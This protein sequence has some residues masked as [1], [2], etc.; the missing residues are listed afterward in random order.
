M[1]VGEGQFLKIINHGTKELL[2]TLKVLDEQTIHGI[3]CH[4]D[5]QGYDTTSSWATLLVWGGSYVS[6]IEVIIS[7]DLSSTEKVHMN[8][9]L[10]PID[11]GDWIL[12]ACFIIPDTD[13]SPGGS[14]GVGA[15]LV[16]AHNNVLILQA[17]MLANLG[18]SMKPTIKAVISGPPSM[19]YSAH[20]FPTETGCV[21]S[22]STGCVLVAAGTFFGETILWSFIPGSYDVSRSVLHRIFRGHQGSVFGVQISEKSENGASQRLL[23][24]CSDDRTIRIWDVSNLSTYL[25]ADEVNPYLQTSLNVETSEASSVYSVA[26]GMGHASRIWGLRFLGQRDGYWGLISYGED[27]TAQTWLLYPKPSD[28]AISPKSSES[29]IE[30]QHLKTYRYH[31]G[32]N[33]NAITIF[34]DSIDS[35]L[36]ADGGA[37]GQITSYYVTINELGLK[38]RD[39]SYHHRVEDVYTALPTESKM[40]KGFENSNSKQPRPQIGDI[41][42]SLSGYWQLS[43]K[44]IG[45]SGSEN[46]GNLEGTATFTSRHPTDDS[47][48][49]EELYSEVGCFI[50]PKGLRFETYRQ[51]VWRFDTLTQNIDVWFV[52]ADDQ[53]SVDYL[54]HA[55]KF[56]DKDSEG[57]RDTDM[58]ELTA[59][60]DHLCGK[61]N[62]QVKYTFQVENQSVTRW[63]TR[64][65]VCG[66]SK[67]YV[68]ESTYTRKVEPEP[69]YDNE[70]ILTQLPTPEPKS[71]GQRIT[72]QSQSLKNHSQKPEHDAFKTFCWLNK[73]EFLVSTE[74]GI[75]LLGTL[76]HDQHNVP[77]I[78]YHFVARQKHLESSCIATSIRSPAVAWLTGTEGS[79]YFY[80]HSTRTLKFMFKLPK[81]VAFL[82]A[83]VLPVEWGLDSKVD[84]PDS[85]D[86]PGAP[87]QVGSWKRK[88]IGIVATSLWSFS[89]SIIFFEIVGAGPPTDVKF[90]EIK[91]PADFVVT[92]SHFIEKEGGF[93]VLGSRKG[94]L[95]VWD[96]TAYLDAQIKPLVLRVLVHD[97]SVTSIV[98][99]QDESAGSKN[100]MIN[101]VTTG[102]DGRYKVH[103][104]TLVSRRYNGDDVPR[105]ET[106]HDCKLSFGPFIEGAYLSPLYKELIFWGF[107]SK[108]FVVW[109][110]SQ[111]AEVI[112]VECGNAHRNWDFAPHDSGNCGG[113]FVWTQAKLC[114]VHCQDNSSHSII[115]SGGHGREIK[116]IALSPSIQAEDNSRFRLLATGAEDTIIRLSDCKPVDDSRLKRS[117]IVKGHTTGI[118]QLRWS[119]DGRRLFSAAGYEEFIIWRIRLVPRVGLG[120]TCEAVCPKVTE[121][122]DL[123]IM[124]FDVVTMSHRERDPEASA[125][126]LTMAYSDSSLRLFLYQSWRKQKF[127]NIFNGSSGSNC[128]TQARF[129]GSIQES[130]LYVC[131]ASTNGGVDLWLLGTKQF[132]QNA[133]LIFQEAPQWK[134]PLFNHASSIKCSDV[135]D[136]SPTE[137][138]IISGGDGGSVAFTYVRYSQQASQNS[139][140]ECTSTMIRHYHASAVTGLKCIRV[141]Q[142]QT[143]A[144]LLF[145]SVGNDQ[146]LKLSKVRINERTEGLPDI[147]YVILADVYTNVGDAAAL[148]HFDDEDGRWL[149]VAGIGTETWQMVGA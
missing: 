12:D 53:K 120:V 72:S 38:A 145:A 82:Q 105:L 37:D 86:S 62:Y 140:V 35:C 1:F 94:D 118:Q 34:K 31:S 33:I 102:R 147:G 55:L 135:L 123:R 4:P 52:K 66:P 92:S 17:I 141:K 116:A 142:G 100:S 133:P 19:L 80:H 46:F 113:S 26:V 74:K 5:D 137:S 48:N 124:D 32:K 56:P 43:R 91:L 148:E 83:Q 21:R 128:L 95:G 129:L 89:L 101:L 76:Q 75:L 28:D 54:Y 2:K 87:F 117:S 68:L 71:E 67:D 61:D 109:N 36:I 146:R 85:K 93:L 15:F 50:S 88:K 51:Y 41:F 30:L 127:T 73:S 115:K 14:T 45:E 97:E 24:S 22:T 126:L 132:P 79:I 65:T 44:C 8:V 58:L 103:E 149:L 84:W 99:L 107:R 29:K 49:G 136:L 98:A 63:T 125:Y 110:E 6:V 57:Q 18:E 119:K 104:L 69:H 27:A 111:K 10:L 39:R 108:A 106:V 16:N 112:S 9:L 64:T 3:V 77:S 23:A 130:E 122:S 81:K 13:E 70:S 139:L 59:S 47:R 96:V 78:S 42:H 40:A 20:I 114:H 60:G 144:S 121:S 25:R 131:T 138:L 90:V 143:E 11:T 134:R 7:H